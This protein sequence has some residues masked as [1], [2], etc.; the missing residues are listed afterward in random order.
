MNSDLQFYF[1]V[2]LYQSLVE[3]IVD[4]ENVCGQFPKDTYFVHG[5]KTVSISKPF[6]RVLVMYV[7]LTSWAWGLDF[8]INFS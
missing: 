8:L 5:G 6:F 2:L 4:V 3:Q 1:P 7:Q